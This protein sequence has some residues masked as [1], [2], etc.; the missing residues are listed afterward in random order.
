MLDRDTMDSE[1][2]RLSG[3]V[4]DWKLAVRFNDV[5]GAPADCG[6]RAGRHAV[7]QHSVHRNHDLVR[8][9]Q[10]SVHALAVI[11]HTWEHLS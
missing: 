9:E 6:L 10:R 5:S 4:D 1:A 7:T 3:A 8:A 2:A 11:E